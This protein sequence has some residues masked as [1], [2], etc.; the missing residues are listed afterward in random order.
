MAAVYFD[1]G[2]YTIVNG[3]LHYQLEDQRGTF[4]TE[5]CHGPPP[6]HPEYAIYDQEIYAQTSYDT[7]FFAFINTCM[8]ANITGYTYTDPY[9]NAY[10]A[11]AGGGFVN[12]THAQGMPFAWTHRRVADNPAVNQMSSDG[13]GDPDDGTVC[14]I[15]FSFG[16]AALNQPLRNSDYH[17]YY[18]VYHFFYYAL[19]ADRTINEALDLASHD[20]FYYSPDFDQSPLYDY[21]GFTS[22]WPTYYSDPPESPPEWHEGRGYHSH[23]NV[24][25]N[26]NIKLYEPVVYYGLEISS[27]NG[28]STNPTGTQSYIHDSTAHVEAIPDSGK[29]LHNWILDG[30]ESLGNS[31][32]IEVYMDTNHSL[33][34]E[35][36]NKP[37]Y[38]FVSDIDPYSYNE[39]VSAPYSLAGYQPDGF[40]TTLQFYDPYNYHGTIVGVLNEQTTGQISVYGV[41]AQG[42]DQGTLTVEASNNGYNWV[43]VGT[44]TFTT[45]AEW[46]TIGSCLTP[47][48]YVRLT[49]SGGMGSLGIDC[50]NV[51]PAVYLS[52]DKPAYGVTNYESGYYTYGQTLY[53]TASSSNPA[54][55]FDHWH[56]DGNPTEIYTNPIQVT[57]T[58]DHTLDAHYVAVPQYYLNVTKPAYANVNVSSGYY[59]QG[60][61]INA[62]TYTTNPAYA[63]DYWTVNGYPNYNN[64]VQTTMTSARNL[65]AY[66]K[67]RPYLSITKPAYGVTNYQS[68]YYNQ[69]QVLNIQAWSS[70][71]AYEF[72]YWT[73]NGYPYY[74]NPV[75]V[76]MTSNRNVVAYYKPVTH[77][78]LVGAY[79]Q[80]GQPFSPPVWIDGQQVSPN[81]AYLLSYGYHTI[82]Y[83]PYGFLYSLYYYVGGSAQGGRVVNIFVNSDQYV[84]GI[85]Y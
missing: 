23:M 49:A 22:I 48:S 18:W 43:T 7:A 31:P 14:Y 46:A 29:V 74:S 52:I 85:Y 21:D 58:Q 63:F 25:G 65:V 57:M 32:F 35:F 66:Y 54:Y 19:T 17:Y 27:S 59:P 9:G 39:W 47:F 37:P 28:G 26:G 12:S 67:T 4:T 44:H 50:V 71:P 15:G 5:I 62:Y 42:G 53:V 60:T 2:V 6:D 84:F 11:L 16:S 34:A 80:N 8:S 55:A 56:V 24:Y 73:V 40:C 75:Q 1:H 72:D 10:P 64:P 38:S 51:T 78:V 82:E 41:S 69:G 30:T 70:D 45:T 81:Q 79:H 3:E 68:G 36:T 83:H 76:T 61:V 20:T 13:Y 77:Y 33:Y